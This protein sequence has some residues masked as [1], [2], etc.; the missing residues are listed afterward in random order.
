MNLSCK[1]ICVL[2]PA[3]ANIG[4]VKLTRLVT[5][6]ARQLLKTVHC[7]AETHTQPRITV[8]RGFRASQPLLFIPHPG[9]L[10]TRLVSSCLHLAI[11]S[12]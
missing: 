9:W 7:T 11:G 8:L 6:D 1:G 5:Q 10:P 3:K 4:S 12:L 2:D